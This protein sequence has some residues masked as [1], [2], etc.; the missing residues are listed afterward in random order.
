[1]FDQPG[2]RRSHVFSTPRGGGIAMV[3]TLLLA[4][5]G[6]WPGNQP[7]LLLAF[8]I[9]LIAVGGI[10]WI[11]DHRSLSA[12][13]RLFVHMGAALAFACVL[14]RE[15]AN[16]PSGAS[17][18]I[19]IAIA[20]FWLVACV[21][22]W[23]FMDGSNGLVTLQSAFIALVM[24]AWHFVAARP[25]DDAPLMSM[26]MSLVVFAACL[27]FLPFNF[28]KAR[29]FMGDVGSGGLGFACG[30]L[31]LA[32]VAKNPASFWPMLLPPSALL[33]DASLT[34]ASRMLAGKNWTKPH[35]EHLYQWLIRIG[36]SHARVALLYLA[37]GI[38]VTVPC[39]VAIAKYPAFAA[40]LA[41]LELAA[42]A[43]L[44][45]FTRRKL[46]RNIRSR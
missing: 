39:L 45:F 40:P 43:T 37:W 20:T 28:P 35:R 8:G 29:I 15:T 34:L 38:F 33:I 31:L 46:L 14:A 16:W 13:T 42:G 23:N 6:L 2:Q 10:G 9:G 27:G 32:M 18:F 36:L 11:D 25:H 41:L 12:R 3:L 1:M 21:N 30:A 7:A 17:G 44:W 5:C 22:F 19:L 26:S 4:A 24:V